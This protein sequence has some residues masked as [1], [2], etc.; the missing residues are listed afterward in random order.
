MVQGIS[1]DGLASGLNTQ[2]IIEQLMEIERQPIRR[3]EVQ[4]DQALLEKEIWQEVNTQLSTLDQNMSAL[5]QKQY[6]CEQTGAGK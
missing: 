2:E 1:F 4:K 6:F 5:D 3:Y